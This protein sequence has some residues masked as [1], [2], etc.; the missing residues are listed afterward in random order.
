M[1]LKQTSAAI[2]LC[3]AFVLAG[4]QTGVPQAQDIPTKSQLV[5]NSAGQWQVLA[6]WTVTQLSGS[7]PA[8]RRIAVQAPDDSAFAR[9]FSEL[10]ATELVKRGYIVTRAEGAPLLHFDVEVVEHGH[11][12]PPQPLAFTFLGAL[13]GVGAWALDT[14]GVQPALAVATGLAVGPAIDL[15]R[16]Y[17]PAPSDTEVSVTTSISRSGLRYAARSD[18]FYISKS[19]KGDYVGS[20]LDIQ[21]AS[22]TGEFP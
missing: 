15:K 11:I 7:L 5:L 21:S 1:G 12:P 17:F 9:G 2:L 3:A 13:G 22:L 10:L 18:V 19:D 6:G 20:D 16:G 8:D 4:C 14:N